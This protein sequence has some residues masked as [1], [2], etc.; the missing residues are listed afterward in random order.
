MDAKDGMTLA[1]AKGEVHLAKVDA[2][3]AFARKATGN[4]HHVQ[5]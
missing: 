4:R 5:A 1:V 3:E 2:G